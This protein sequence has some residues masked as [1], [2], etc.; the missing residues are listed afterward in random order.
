MKT[1]TRSKMVAGAM[2]L[3]RRRGVNATSVREVVRHTDTPRGSIRH[4]FPLG[5]LQ[6]VEEAVRFAGEEVGL[7]LAALMARDGT[8][9]G[10]DAFISLW[11]QV[12]EESGFEAGC[13]VL[14]VA[15]E[16]YMGEDGNP[17]PEG[18][19]RLLAL[20]DSIFREWHGTLEAALLKDGVAPPRARRL[21]RLIIA[22]VEGTV[23]LCRAARSAAPLDEVRA[24]LQLALAAAL[25][26]V[27]SSA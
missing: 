15:I 18:E 27:P 24:E 14:A 20:A 23:A 16:Q 13:P 6:L 10:L 22:S 19:T 21:A 4:H 26:T 25:P 9:A 3:I 1:G 17:H 8:L 2:D 11:R 7:P 12:L 5:K